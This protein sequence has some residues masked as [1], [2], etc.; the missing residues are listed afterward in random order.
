MQQTI[1]R[2]KVSATDPSPQ[3]SSEEGEGE[4]QEQYQIEAITDYRLSK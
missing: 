2:Q 1:K 4:E 3:A